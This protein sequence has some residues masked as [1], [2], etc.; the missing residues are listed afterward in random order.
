MMMTREERIAAA[1]EEY[2]GLTVL[3]PLAAQ[4]PLV[5]GHGP[6]N[7]PFAVVGEAPGAEEVR[8]GR[9]FVGRS[10][11]LLFQLLAEAGVQRRWCY[12]TNTVPYRP[13]GNRTPEQFEIAASRRRL[14]QEIIA[15]RPGLVICC[16]ATAGHAV[17][18]SAGRI[19]DIHG[20]LQ[21]AGFTGP[22]RPFETWWLPTFHPAAALR[23]SGIEDLM[24]EDL[25]VLR[26]I[27][28]GMKLVTGT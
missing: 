8:L 16:G 2:A 20:R 3:A 26:R 17:S 24:R 18:P 5:P 28:D 13:P 1:Y 21:R 9:P 12:V 15:V 11:Q 23:S 14:A 27:S 10:G 22:P 25:A 6:L 7:A 4:S 19:S